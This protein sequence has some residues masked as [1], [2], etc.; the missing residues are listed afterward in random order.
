MKQSNGF[1]QFLTA[2]LLVGMLSTPA[3]GQGLSKVGTTAAKFLTIPVGPRATALGG[4]F[5]AI[6]NDATAMYWNPSG[7]TRV[8][9][10][11]FTASHSF[12]LA[13]IQYD[14]LGLVLPMGAAGTAGFSVTAMTMGQMDITTEEEPEGTGGTFSA[15][16]F[17]IGVSYARDLTDFFSIGGS[18]KYIN[19]SIW[20]SSATGLAVDLGTLFQTP[21]RGVRFG[22]SI[23]NFGGKLQMSGPDLLVQKD[24]DEQ[25]YG[26]N[27]AI[28]ALLSTDQFDLPLI[29]RIG[30]AADIINTEGSQLTLA[31]DASHPNDNVQSVSLGGEFA[32]L[33]RTLFLRGGLRNLGNPESE[34]RW[35]VGAGLERE[36]VSGLRLAFDYAYQSFGRLQSVHKLGVAIR[37]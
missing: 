21:I 28:S 25:K 2:V 12:W 23:S 34:E 20:N 8:N 19:E 9:Y 36:V 16:S 5:V 6:A 33:E 27:P 35:V 10:L 29:L 14:Y 37:I 18:V 30:I 3:N 13:D 17:A 24:I 4:A 22:A 1:A 11:E 15:G 7:L 26:N 31:V 32:F